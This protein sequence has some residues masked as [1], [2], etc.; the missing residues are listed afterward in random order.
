M[1]QQVTQMSF[2]NS[3]FECLSISE[4]HATFEVGNV[5]GVA[6]EGYGQEEILTG[7]IREL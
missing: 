6:A 1:I 7:S 4:V 5:V 2:R 3:S